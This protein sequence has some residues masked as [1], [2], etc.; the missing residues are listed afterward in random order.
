MTVRFRRSALALVSAAT[1]AVLLTLGAGAAGAKKG[2]GR[3]V[4]KVVLFASDGMRPDLMEKYAKAGVDADLQGADEARARPATTGCS[5]PSRRTPASAGTRWPPAPIRP[6]TA[7][8]TTL[9]TAA[10]DAF[11]N[12]TSFSARRRAPGGHDRER[13]RA[14]RQEGRPD[15]LGRR[16]RRE[17]Q[18]P[19]RRLHQL[20][21]QPRRARRRRR[22]PSSRRARRSSASPTRWRRSSRRR[23]GPACRRAT[24]RRRRRRRSGRSTRRSPPRTRT[25]PTTSTSTTASPAAASNYD[26]AIVSPVGKTGASPS[27]DLKVGDFLPLKL[28]GANGLIGARAGQTVGALHQADLARARR[29]QLQAVRHL[30]RTRDRQV[31]HAVRRP[32][33]RRRRRGPAREVHRRQPAAVGR[34]RLRPAGSGRRRRGHL[35]P[36]GPRPR[37]GLQP[38]GD[39]LHP[40]HA[41]ARH[42]S[43]DGRVSV[44]RRGLAPVHGARLADRRPTACRTPATTSTRSSTTSRAPAAA[45]PGASRSAR[46]TSA[47]PTRTPT[48][49]CASRAS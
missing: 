25:A 30:A 5:R 44:H 14:G 31:R 33:G 43:R 21:L 12:W 28:M 34:G 22:T 20:L 37:A 1:L 4:D 39:Q 45:R 13:G 9:S 11:A 19:D 41:P 29:E 49:S 2:D 24:R 16:R 35:R 26:H 32:A 36:A 18:R 47:A 38:P 42:G 10:G 17:H 6:S 40:R 23:A 48:R 7:R 3:P 27:V 8:P 15:R 46:A